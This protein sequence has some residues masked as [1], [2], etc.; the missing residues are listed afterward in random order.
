MRLMYNLGSIIYAER[1]LPGKLNI[2][3]LLD[4]QARTDFSFVLPVHLNGAIFVDKMTEI[5]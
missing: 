2:S 5:G 1:Q 4:I 3:F